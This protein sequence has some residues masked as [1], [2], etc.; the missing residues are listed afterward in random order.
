MSTLEMHPGEISGLYLRA[1]EWYAGQGNI[2]EAVRYALQ[3]QAWQKA[4]YLIEQ[5]PYA[6][7]WGISDHARLRHW[8]EELPVEVGRSRCRL[9]LAYAKT[10][11]MV[12][13][14]PVIEGWLH[15]AAQVAQQ[16]ARLGTAPS[17]LRH[18]MLCW[19]SIFHAD[20]L[21]QW[22]RLDE[23]LD[24]ALQAVQ[25]SEQTETIVSLYLGY[26]LLMRIYLARGEREAARSAFQQ[27]EQAMA[28]TYSSYR[29]NVYIIGDWVQFWL[30]CGEMEHAVDW[31]E[32]L[33]QSDRTATPYLCEREDVARAHILIARKQHPEAL[34]L[35][36]PLLVTAQKQ[37]RQGHVIEM[38]LLQALVYQMAHEEAQ[39][40][41]ILVQ[42][43]HLAEPEGYIRSFVDGGSSM[44][45][46]LVRLREQQ[47]KQGPTP[48]LDTLLAAFPREERLHED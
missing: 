41:S 8:L 20:V 45:A 23:A 34:E 9:C 7:S 35:L 2:D 31:A 43:V 46:L 38:L 21:R 22:N 40:L 33:M 29:R 37:E 26:A 13:P 5:I 17:G 24:L 44:A 10:L 6:L 39:A 14:Y 27:A 1:S 19:T 3:A 32:E 30:T 16:A 42:A 48:Y 15:E 18:A 25:L 36:E 47:L 12:A 28:K 11:F 4:A